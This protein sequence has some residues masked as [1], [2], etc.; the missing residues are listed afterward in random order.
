MTRTHERHLIVRVELLNPAVK[1]PNASA[2]QLAVFEALQ[3]DQDSAARAEGESSAS[4]ATGSK[5]KK[6]EFKPPL[7][8]VRHYC[9]HAG[10][11]LMRTGMGASKAVRAAIAHVRTPVRMSVQ[12]A[13]GSATRARRVLATNY[14]DAAWHAAAGGNAKAVKQLDEHL[15]QLAELQKR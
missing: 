1:P 15:S 11:C 8:Q 10:L 4:G 9:P 13:F 3:R 6:Q 12:Q 14:E 2:L 5:T 7:L